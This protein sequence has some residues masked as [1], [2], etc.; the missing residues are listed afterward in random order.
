MMNI[1]LRSL[2]LPL[3]A[4]LAFTAC[5]EKEVITPPEELAHFQNK[6]GDSYFILTPT[7]TY[8]V[9]IGVTTVSSSARTVSVSVSSPTGA[10]QGSQFTVDNLEV[11]IPAGQATGSIILQGIQAQYLAGR[12]DTLVFTIND[13]GGKVV[14]SDFNNTFRL[15]MRGPCFDGDIGD[16][17]LN[18]M[19]GAYN[20]SFDAGFGA[21]G[22]YKTTIKSITRLSF[23]TARAVI[24]NVWDY[25]FGDVNFIMDWTDPQNTTI[26]VEAPTTLPADAGV[27]NAAYAGMNLV[28]RKHANG[29]NGTFSVCN[30]NLRL[31]YQLGV[32]NT[33]AG[34]LLGFFGNVGVTTMAR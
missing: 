9:P 27:L 7:T 11:T 3:V 2:W 1:R 17:E 26:N 10:V 13:G 34:T 12:R 8:T 28:I 20:N 30:G 14:P 24:E 21:Y 18:A 23:T 33:P 5:K 31:V 25:G 16:A 32:F 4:I 22:P 15:F 29:Q 6:T 19:L